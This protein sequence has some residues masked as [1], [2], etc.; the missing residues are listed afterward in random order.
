MATIISIDGACRGNGKPNCLATGAVYIQHT[1]NKAAL[2]EPVPV[3][4][5]KHER[6]STNQRGELMAM[7]AGLKEGLVLMEFGTVYF[8]TDSEYI[9]NSITKEWF[10]SWKSKNWVTA[11]GDPVKNRDLWEEIANLVDKYN[12]NEG[13]VIYHV[14]GHLVSIGAATA[15][16]LFMHD[17]TCSLLYEVISKKYDENR[18]MNHKPDDFL[19]ALELFERNN[20]FVA[21]TAVFK[22]M[23]ICNTIADIVATVHADNINASS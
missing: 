7:I 9:F 16:K 3:T 13:M 20:G 2:H 15:R 5:S 22:E 8:V 12:H 10:K 14:K 6:P 4:V 21:P 23:I 11:N 17:Y 1:I 18:L 19:H